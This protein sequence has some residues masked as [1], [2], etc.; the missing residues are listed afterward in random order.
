LGFLPFFP[1]IFKVNHRFNHRNPVP[2][3]NGI[4]RAGEEVRVM[5]AMGSQQH[6]GRYARKAR[7]EAIAVAPVPVL[8]PIKIKRAW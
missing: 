7:G 8:I 3:C 6:L 1:S 5:A 4:C 2:G